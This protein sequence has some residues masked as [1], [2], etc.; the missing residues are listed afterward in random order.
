MDQKSILVFLGGAATA[1][2]LVVA[3]VLLTPVQ[4]ILPDG[5]GTAV[6][7]SD[8]AS[9]TTKVPTPVVAAQDQPVWEKDHYV[10]IM[11]FNNEKFTPETLTIN[12][13]DS[14]KFV[15]KDNL[16]M[17]ISASLYAP[18]ASNIVNTDPKSVGKGG[19]YSLSLPQAGIWIIQNEN[20][21]VQGPSGVIYVR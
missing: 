10:Y 14:V 4:V 21:T 13:G 6:V 17:R 8:E 3:Y 16:T 7:A 11:N 2:V 18:D 20:S 19:T 9:T 5:V 1:V 12:K 15:N